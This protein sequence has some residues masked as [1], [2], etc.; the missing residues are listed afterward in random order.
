[1]KFTLIIISDFSKN[2]CL[3]KILIKEHIL[4]KYNNGEFETM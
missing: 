1:M 3:F 4:H 2:I